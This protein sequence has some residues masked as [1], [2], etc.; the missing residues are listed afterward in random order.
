VTCDH[1]QGDSGGNVNV[2]GCDNRGYCEK[3]GHIIICLILNGYKIDL[4][5]FT[6][7]KSP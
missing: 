4:S 7:T 6:S 2:L 3:K 5:E 1:T